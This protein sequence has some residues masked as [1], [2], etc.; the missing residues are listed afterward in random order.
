MFWILRRTGAANFFNSLN[1]NCSTSKGPSGSQ[2]TMDKYVKR[3]PRKAYG[4]LS[5]D[6]DDGASAKHKIDDPFEDI[7][8]F[9]MI[10]PSN[11]GNG[12]LATTTS[13]GCHLHHR[14]HN[15][16]TNGDDGGGGGGGG[17]GSGGGG[18]DGLGGCTGVNC[19]VV[20]DGGD[21]SLCGNNLQNSCLEG[22]NSN[23]NGV[24]GGHCTAADCQGNYADSNLC[25]FNVNN[26]CPGGRSGG[27]G[28]SAVMTSN[29]ILKVT[30]TTTSSSRLSSKE[31][32]ENTINRLQSMAMSDDDDYDESLTCN[33][34]DRAFHCH[35]QLAS[36]QQKKRHFGCG[37]CDSL[38][39]SLMLLEHHKEEFEHWSDDE[40]SRRICCRRNRG[41]DY[42]TDT[43]SFTS[44]AESE[45]LERLL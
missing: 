19:D 14:S 30:S 8:N 25:Q 27:G 22:P 5:A 37:G 16:A 12:G 43:D 35:R 33:V 2:T 10:T 21:C 45:D 24:D 11:N 17:S 41:D 28:T 29:G 1:N 38:F 6:S 39:P 3:P 23:G 4:R 26:V 13:N 44:E 32:N 42:F 36:H 20:D 7:D 40:I 31:V 18:L 9:E 34:C 15:S